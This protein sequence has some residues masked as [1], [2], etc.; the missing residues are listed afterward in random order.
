MSEL[1][2]IGNAANAEPGKVLEYD[3]KAG[4]FKNSAE[5]NKMAVTRTYRKGWELPT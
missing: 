3:G 2:I 5:A 4:R 1:A